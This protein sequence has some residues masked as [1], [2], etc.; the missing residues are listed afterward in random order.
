MNKKGFVFLETIII[1]VIVTISLTTLLSSYTLITSKSREKEYY[2][3]VSD[4]YLLYSLSNLGTTDAINYRSLASKLVK[5]KSKTCSASDSD[6][7]GCLAE[8]LGVLSIDVLKKDCTNI[9][10][11]YKVNNS[12][13]QGAAIGEFCKIFGGTT[14]KTNVNSN[15]FDKVHDEEGNCYAVFSEIKLIKLYFVSD[16]G[17]ALKQKEATKFFNKDN[18]V[19][20]YMK[21]LKKC[22]DDVYVEFHDSNGNVCTP[23]VDSDCNNRVVLNKLPDDSNPEKSC[24][25]PVK[26]MIGVFERNS[27]YYYASIEI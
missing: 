5:N 8:K 21:T 10:D 6:Y 18:G 23:G 16:I 27:D 13:Y 11:K 17:H 9:C 7:K 4:K 14:A 3:R 25:N 19:I 1:L 12:I 26:Y 22:Y 15:T 20:E 24:N 2:D